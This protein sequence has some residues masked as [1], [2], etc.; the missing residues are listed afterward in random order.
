MTADRLVPPTREEMQSTGPEPEAAVAEPTL[1]E[2]YRDYYK[3]VSEL[4]DLP[5]PE[6]LIGEVLHCR[7]YH[8]LRGRDSTYKSFL[9]LD[10]ALS[11]ATG[12]S[13]NDRA[14]HRGRVLFIAGEGVEGLRDRTDAWAADR[15]VTVSEQDFEVRTRALNMYDPGED[16]EELLERV[17]VEAYDLV[18]IDTLRRVSGTADENSSQMGVVVDNIARIQRAALNTAVLVIAHTTKKDDDTRGF[19]GIEDDADV[20]WASAVVKGEV[21]LRNV[22]MKNGPQTA[23]ITLEVRPV[24]GNVVLSEKGP[25]TTLTEDEDY[26]YA[27]IKKNPGGKKGSYSTRDRKDV[28]RVI[29]SLIKRGFARQERSGNERLIFPVLE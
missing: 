4:R 13:W 15:G 22:K 12:T 5:P 27:Q 8:V 2:K 24:E 21:L 25:S 19:S 29:D 3:T 11:I 20:V 7:G 9:A 10:W 26:V 17:A 16:F 23:T 28:Y 1:R 14:V 18:I 6:P